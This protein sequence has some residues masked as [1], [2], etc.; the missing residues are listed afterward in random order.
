M[1]GSWQPGSRGNARVLPLG[2]PVA[3]EPR[4]VSSPPSPDD[5]RSLAHIK[6]A[7]GT[8]GQAPNSSRATFAELHAG[9]L[10]YV[11][12]WGRWME[13]TGKVWRQDD[14][15]AAFDHVR[16]VCR[17]AAAQCKKDGVASAIASAKTVAAVERLAKADRRLAG[18]VNQWDADP[19]LL[20]TPGGVV[21]LQ[22]GE[23]R[24]HQA[25]DFITK[26]TATTPSGECPLWHRFLDRIT[27]GDAELSAYLQRMLGYSLTGSTREHALFF[28]YGRGANGKSVLLSTVAGILGDYH[29]AAPIETFT[30]SHSDRHPTELAMLRGARLVTAVETEEGRRWAEA[31]IKYLTGGDPVAAR[32]MRQDFFE[33]VPTFKLIIA[34]NHKPGLRSVDEAIRRRFNLIPFNV[35]IPLEERDQ[36]LA[37]KL[38]AEW[39]GILGWM[40]AGCLEWQ[41][42][43]LNAPEAV[44]LAT[45]EY[46][47]SEDALAAWID[48]EC[49]RDAN[50]WERSTVL[51]ASW[52]TWAELHG[53]QAGD[54]KR[55]RDRLEGKD[56]IS[57]KR[58]PGTGR[59]GYQGIR[60]KAG[61]QTD[62]D[63]H[64]R[65]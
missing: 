7:L 64:W 57:H 25:D 18:T 23:R 58:E 42:C 61:E 2:L 14:T 13:W 38:K 62:S 51:F 21:D 33:Y 46:L 40:I 17:E 27:A 65:R 12:G 44:R 47:A 48:E 59:K 63:P 8:L 55:F 56:G 52:K 26:F 5:P 39:P 54:T 35:T 31:R 30:I 50:A 53:G 1:R 32:F 9:N 41:R 4:T 15:L 20:N 34:G 24:P 29:R 11:A 43:G 36:E 22:N 3:S 19:W 60:L 6:T 16:A 37:E 45:A 10:R 28:G 49:E